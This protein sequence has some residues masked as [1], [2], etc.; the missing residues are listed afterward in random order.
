MFTTILLLLGPALGFRLL[1]ALGISRFASWRASA[2]HGLAIMLVATAAAHFVPS[3][4]TVMP[5]H[6]DLAAMVPPFV[7]FPR[8]MVYVTGVLELLGAA[9]LV[10]ATTRSAAGIGLAALFVLMLPANIYA[11]IEDIP[12]DGNP[13]TPLWFRVP[14]QL[15][16]IAIALWAATATHSTSSRRL[17]AG[18]RPG[19]RDTVAT[20]R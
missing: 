17:L 1:G 18:T 10:R 19:T 5:S 6:D 13:A 11:A 16:F 8:A 14:E 9:G 2:I 20:R 7:P 12:L 15:L 3:S 4:V